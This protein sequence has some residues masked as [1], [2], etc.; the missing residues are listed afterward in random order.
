MASRLACLLLL[1]P[2]DDVAGCEYAR[3]V[4]Y[5]EGRLDLDVARRG[6]GV[7]SER[8]CDD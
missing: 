5:L 3:V 4:G 7:G 8:A 6:E 1:L 2:F